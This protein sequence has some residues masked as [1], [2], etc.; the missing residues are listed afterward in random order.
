MS[1]ESARIRALRQLTEEARQAPSPKLDWDALEERLFTAEPGLTLARVTPSRA[2]WALLAAAAAAVVAGGVGLRGGAPSQ[3]SAAV[4]E[5][6][7]PRV[8]GPAGAA[9]DGAALIEGDRVLAGDAPVVVSEPG[10]ATWTLAPHGSATLVDAGRFRTVRL[11]AGAISVAVVPKLAPESFAIEVGH[12]R[13]A[14]HGTRF[15]VK[16]AGERAEVTLEEGVVAVG[17]SADRGRTR[18][19]VM[20]APSTGRFS[21]D[22][23]KLGEVNGPPADSLEAARAG[24]EDERAATPAATPRPPKSTGPSARPEPDAARPDVPDAVALERGAARVMALVEECFSKGTAAPRGVA[25]S[26]RVSLSFSVLPSGEVA[27]LTAEP[28]LSP[29][30]QAC[31]ERELSGPLFAAS[32]RG[33]TITRT[34]H[35]A[36]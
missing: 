29:E 31:S 16:R 23:A 13:V 34:L 26:A 10:R 17:A 19:F 32:R 12:T 25:I 24:A 18:G 20:R 2:R 14:A 33:A 15:T 5:P 22:G 8:F 6:N 30:V 1:N 11:E 4:S 3:P 9:L 7:H 28:P 35:L 36:R 27:A 21:L